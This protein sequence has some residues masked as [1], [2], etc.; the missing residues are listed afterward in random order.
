MFYCEKL[1]ATE[2]F[3]LVKT[4]CSSKSAN[5]TDLKI[6]DFKTKGK[7]LVVL[8]GNNTK[9]PN[10]AAAYG[11]NCY[12]W[13]SGYANKKSVDLYSIYYPIEQPLLNDLTLNHK[14]D[15]EDLFNTLFKPILYKKGKLKSA[16]EIAESLSDI[17][18]FGHSIGGHIMNELA[19]SFA[20]F[21]KSKNFTKEEMNK[22]FS[23]IVFIGYSPFKLVDAPIKS[24]YIAPLYD[25]LG[26]TKLVYDKMQKGGKYL[27]SNPNI[28]FDQIYKLRE[29]AH[30]DYIKEYKKHTSNEPIQL[31][32][33][34][35]NLIITPNLLYF[36]GIKEDHNLAGVINY[37]NP[38]PYKTDAGKLTTEL[39]IKTFL[40]AL[41]TTRK[42]FSTKHLYNEAIKQ[43]EN[44]GDENKEL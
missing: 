18:F 7:T 10:K 43:T 20:K 36:D 11:A 37:K 32:V 34:K 21:M 33:N 16:E 5:F 28:K 42:K 41:T 9:T 15:Y 30:H 40:Y 25:S 29:K 17:T 35:N 3:G 4:T 14:F 31:F 44:I 38:S 2:S 19:N 23:S 27:S 13:L 24:V 22:V 1:K 12:N 26:S 8:C 39:F 6:S